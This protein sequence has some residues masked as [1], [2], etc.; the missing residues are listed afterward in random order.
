MT[1]S[2]TFLTVGKVWIICC[3]SS[4][5]K[6]LP[7]IAHTSEF[8]LGREELTFNVMELFLWPKPNP[9]PTWVLH[10]VPRVSNTKTV[11]STNPYDKYLF[12]IGQVYRG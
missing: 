8:S 1:G 12:F 9:R 4:D 11:S 3:P 6:V 2:H 10:P 5:R 7:C